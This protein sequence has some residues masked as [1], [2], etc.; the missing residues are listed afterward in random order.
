[1]IEERTGKLKQ[2]LHVPRERKSLTLL[3]DIVYSRT[4]DD[5]GHEVVLHLSLLLQHGNVEAR[6]ANGIKPEEYKNGEK[7]PLL[8][9]LPGGGY[10][11]KNA[12]LMVPELTYLAESG[13]AVAFV[14]Y[15]SSEIAHF[16]AQII[17]VK[18][19]IRFLRAHSEMYNLDSGRIGVMGRS[20]GGHLAALAGMNTEDFLGDE[21]LEYSSN[22]DA[23]CDLF[24]PVDVPF[25]LNKELECIK[26]NPNYRW[27]RLEDTHPGVLMG[28][29]IQ[30]MF[31]RAL[32]ASPPHILGENV[33]PMVIMHGAKDRH[34]PSE[35]SEAFYQKLVEAG[36]GDQTDYYVIDTADHG[37]DEFFS[38][39]VK[40]II[41]D[42]FDR[43]I[44]R[45]KS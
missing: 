15:R 26:E 36:F 14:Q 5:E 41:L 4:I 34:V 31:E 22:V 42:F 1:L 23:V 21:F 9:W 43:L 29:D 20:A 28:G 37:S 33:C 7:H 35:V 2:I 8:L 32:K 6:M 10:R 30:T 16:P 12:N 11:C 17:D 25:L 38:N 13:Y 44:K 19:A 3:E 18:T 40:G 39:Q 24:G 45:K 27:K